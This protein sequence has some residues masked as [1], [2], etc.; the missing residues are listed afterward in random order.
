M[1]TLPTFGDWAIVPEHLKTKTGLGKMGLKLAPGQEPVAIKTHWHY[2][3]EDY[4]L[5]DVGMAIPKR[6]PTKAQLK[7]LEQN[8]IK[9]RTCNDCKN[10]FCHH[11][12]LKRGLCARCR[13]NRFLNHSRKEA[14]AWAVETITLD[15][16]IV[17]TETTGLGYDDEIIQ[18]AIVNLE[19]DVLFQSQFKPT[20]EIAPGAESVHGL[21]LESLA[22]APAF[23]N[24][25]PEIK[26]LL[27]GKALV[28]YNR[29]FDLRMIEQTCARYEL[30]GIEWEKFRCAMLAYAEY[31]GSWSEYHRSFTWQS[32]A[33]ACELLGVELNNSHHATADALATVGLIRSLAGL[34]GVEAE[35]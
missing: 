14:V 24:L 19:G 5:Y 23:I 33:V 9:A 27:Q 30:P 32:L 25:Y 18:L 29:D 26:N 13:R 20:V 34:E 22:D 7:T 12:K 17:D 8:R 4:E 6:K 21:S 15:C 3:K 10:T 11:T 31:H 28:A 2:S 16:L 35:K 1:T